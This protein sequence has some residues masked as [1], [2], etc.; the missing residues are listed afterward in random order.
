MDVPHSILILFRTFNGERIQPETECWLVAGPL[1]IIVFYP[2]TIFGNLM[3]LNM[4][5]AVLL[6]A[7]DPE[8]LK[9]IEKYD[10]DQRIEKEIE[11]FKN[12]FKK[13]FSCCFCAC[14]ESLPCFIKRISP[15]NNLE[16][17]LDSIDSDQGSILNKEKAKMV[18]EERHRKLMLKKKEIMKRNQEKNTTNKPKNVLE[19]CLPIF[20]YRKYKIAYCYDKLFFQ[21]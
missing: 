14:C 17:S 5:L 4:V 20:C 19:R 8:N 6:A 16:T 10:K 18:Q 7:F 9:K 15:E 3:I 21:N 12:F 11:R 2:I 1:C 13:F